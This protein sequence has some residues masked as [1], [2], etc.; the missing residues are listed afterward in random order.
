MSKVVGVGSAA[1]PV[2]RKAI[3][4]LLMYDKAIVSA[5]AICVAVV[6]AISLVSVVDI[7][8]LNEANRLFSISAKGRYLF[9][10]ERLPASPSPVSVSPPS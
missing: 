10:S 1:A 9:A 8:F 5:P 2:S 4:C 6:V 3:V 7:K